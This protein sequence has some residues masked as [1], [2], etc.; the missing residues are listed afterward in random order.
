MWYLI[1]RN[2]VIPLDLPA[3]AKLYNV[4]KSSKWS[5][6]RKL[7]TAERESVV[8]AIREKIPMEIAA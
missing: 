8:N 2:G 6:N 4:P 1:A 3:L 7:R 5:N